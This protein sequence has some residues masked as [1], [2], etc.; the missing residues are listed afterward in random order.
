MPAEWH[1]RADVLS[2]ADGHAEVWV[3]V[4]P[5]TSQLKGNPGASQPGNRD[6]HQLQCWVGCPPYKVPDGYVP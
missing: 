2:F 4:D 1:A 6:L 5:R 3:W